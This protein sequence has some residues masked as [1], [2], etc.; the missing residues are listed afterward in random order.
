MAYTYDAAE[1]YELKQMKYTKLMDKHNQLLTRVISVTD[2]VLREQLQDE[3]L[4]IADELATCENEYKSMESQYSKYLGQLLMSEFAEFY[5]NNFI[6]STLSDILIDQGLN[7][8]TITKQLRMRTI[9]NLT[10]KREL[11]L[12]L[13]TIRAHIRIID[14]CNSTYDIIGKQDNSKEYIVRCRGFNGIEGYNVDVNN[15]VVCYKDKIL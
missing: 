15:C 8:L 10:Q 7:L 4:Q 11:C 14:Y 12:L 1:Q 5:A 13:N 6:D 2:E 9:D 3:Y